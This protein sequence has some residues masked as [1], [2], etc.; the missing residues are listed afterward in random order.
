[1][2]VVTGVSSYWVTVHFGGTVTAWYAISKV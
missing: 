2:V 1:V